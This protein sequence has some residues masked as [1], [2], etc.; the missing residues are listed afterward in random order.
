MLSLQDNRRFFLY[1]VPSDMR[2]SFDR[3][4]G[5]VKQQM[6]LS[7]LSGDV[8]IFINKRRNQIKLLS[9]D[10]DGFCIYHKRLQKGTFELPQPAPHA[11]SILLTALQLRFILEG[12]QLQSIQ[13][14]PRFKLSA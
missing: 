14:R 10:K 3:L 12:I 4:G 7:L 11:T 13:H 9:W 6:N 8:F 2:K 5:L 1:P